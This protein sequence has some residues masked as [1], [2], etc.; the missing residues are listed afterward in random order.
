MLPP[1]FPE[2][3]QPD[4]PACSSQRHLSKA[5]RAAFAAPTTT[6]APTHGH[7]EA[8][9]HRPQLDVEPLGEEAGAGYELVLRFG[10]NEYFEDDEL[11]KRVALVQEDGLPP[12]CRVSGCQPRWKGPVRGSRLTVPYM[13]MHTHGKHLM[14]FCKRLQPAAA[15]RL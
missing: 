12:L 11:R 2:S 5:H 6:H 3:R 14:P 4:R 8:A 1:A 7:A 9:P 13:E 15:V 10:E